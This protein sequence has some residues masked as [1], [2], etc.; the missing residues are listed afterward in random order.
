MGPS[1]S[2]AGAVYLCAREGLYICVFA[3]CYTMIGNL[4]ITKAL[5]E[6]K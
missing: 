3:V 5:E 1:A 6:F 2:R 4:K